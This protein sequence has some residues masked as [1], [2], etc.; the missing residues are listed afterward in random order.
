MRKLFGVFLCLVVFFG[1]AKKPEDANMI[2]VWHW[3]TDRDKA[4]QELAKR[5]EEQTG[6]KFTTTSFTGDRP[7]LQ[8]RLYYLDDVYVCDITGVINNDL[9]GDVAVDTLLP[10]ANGDSAGFTVFGSQITPFTKNFQAVDDP[11]A[12]VR[13]PSGAGARVTGSGISGDPFI[14]LA[15]PIPV[16]G[17]PG[18]QVNTFEKEYVAANIIGTLD[19]YKFSDLI[20]GQTSI[21][22]VE[23]NHLMRTSEDVVHSVFI[24]VKTPT[25]LSKGD[26]QEL[27]VPALRYQPKSRTLEVNPET[28]ELWEPS[29]VNIT[30]YGFE[31]E[32]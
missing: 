15:P 1:C 10:I 18:N 3:M 5:Y 21:N 17:S 9:L 24:V 2:T 19:L 22:A 25:L 11:A 30:Q 28:D 20:L 12:L 31:I 16:T 13:T 14:Q 7:D 26:A 8:A 32:S 6:I 29:E 4:F 27:L 23:P